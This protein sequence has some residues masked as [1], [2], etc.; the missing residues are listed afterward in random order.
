M[1]RA[2]PDLQTQTGV[3]L[4]LPLETGS[5]SASE[6]APTPP[7]G[8]LRRVV[9]G[10]HPTMF[11]LRRGRRRT[12]GFQIDD[13]GLTVSAPRWASLREVEAAI[14]EKQRWITSK[15]E[16]WQSERGR[17]DATAHR[18]VDGTLLPY[19]GQ[20]MALRLRG[21]AEENTVMRSG[22]DGPELC[23][24]LDP[25]SAETEVRSA[26][27]A[28]ITGEAQR[29]LKERIE[30]LAARGQVRPRSWKLSCARTRW[31][32]C[33]EDGHI[34]LS[35]RLVFFPLDVI[36]YVVA[37]E[38]AHLTALDHGP[39]FWREVE[40]LLPRYEAARARIKGEEMARLPL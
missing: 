27:Q 33:N 38:L 7:P 6:A 29:V 40:R 3:Q 30:L 18:L 10:G 4:G 1:R 32:S 23:L 8:G 31:G 19:L 16:Q 28:W 2:R 12:I 25:A 34:R 15:L 13:H 22:A 14:V 9:L 26:L 17:R 5:S 36:D 11:R 39:R 20:T 35:W 21:G 37:H 24:P